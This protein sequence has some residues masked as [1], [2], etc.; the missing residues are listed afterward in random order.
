M[1]LERAYLLSR[2]CPKSSSFSFSLLSAGMLPLTD[3][4]ATLSVEIWTSMDP[5]L[6]ATSMRFLT[7]PTLTF[8]MESSAAKCLTTAAQLIIVSNSHPSSFSRRFW[9][10]MSPSTME[11][12]FRES[13]EAIP[14]K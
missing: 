13:S 7:P 4:P 10:V 11:T 9:S 1:N 3:S 8:S 5:V 14:P 6:S 12:S 2:F